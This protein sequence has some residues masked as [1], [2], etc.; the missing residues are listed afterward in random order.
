[1][2]RTADADYKLGN[3]GINLPKGMLISIPTYAIHRD[4]NVFPEPDKFNPDR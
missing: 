2:D 3:T 1:M 4:P